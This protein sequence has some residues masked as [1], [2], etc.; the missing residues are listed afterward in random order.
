[1]Q[2]DLLAD[3]FDFAIGG[4]TPSTLGKINR[5]LGVAETLIYGK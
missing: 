3:S 1:M 4:G 5:S 2:G